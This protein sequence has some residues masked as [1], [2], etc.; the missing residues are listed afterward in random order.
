MI[1]LQDF[2]KMHR[3]DEDEDGLNSRQAGN[4]VLYKVVIVVWISQLCSHARPLIL[5][6][7][8][9]SDGC[10]PLGRV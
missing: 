7:G 1:F 3:N 8:R 4:I 10:G 9:L 2:G 6:L 5:V